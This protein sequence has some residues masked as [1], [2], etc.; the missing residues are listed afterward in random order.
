KGI[1]IAVD[2]AADL[3]RHVVGDV[4]RVRQVLQNLLANAIKFTD[5]GAIVVRLTA[6]AGPLVRFE[7]TDTGAG[8]APE[9]L[10]WLFDDFVQADSTS[11]RRY[12]G[13]GLG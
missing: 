10:P 2:V 13:A 1:A 7:V 12:G 3:P 4:A 5:S 11:S 9:V 6:D 8:I